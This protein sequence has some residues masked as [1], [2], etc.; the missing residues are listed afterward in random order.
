MLVPFRNRRIPPPVFLFFKA[1]I[2]KNIFQSHDICHIAYDNL[3][4]RRKKVKNKK[5]E[6][7]GRGAEKIRAKPS[8]LYSI[9]LTNNEECMVI[10]NE[11]L[12]FLSY[13]MESWRR[14]GKVGPTSRNP[15][16]L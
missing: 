2:E 10:G 5:R 1:R 7:G 6:R 12:I 15:F 16:Y 3:I 4:I 13:N 8:L 9:Y 14:G 11:F